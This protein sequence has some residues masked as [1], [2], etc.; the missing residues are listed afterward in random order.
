MATTEGDTYRWVAT[1]GSGND[2]EELGASALFG[3]IGRLSETPAIGPRHGIGA[4][5]QQQQS[6]PWRRDLQENSVR[7]ESPALSLFSGE[8]PP[9]SPQFEDV[10]AQDIFECRETMQRYWKTRPSNPRHTWAEKGRESPLPLLDDEMPPQSP[11]FADISPQDIIECRETMR[12]YWTPRQNF[13]KYTSEKNDTSNELLEDEMPP[14]SP[15]FSD[16]SAQDIANYRETIR[17]ARASFS[18]TTT[19]QRSTWCAPK[20]EPLF[21]TLRKPSTALPRP[22]LAG[23][24]GLQTQDSGAFDSPSKLSGPSASLVPD[25]DADSDDWILNQEPPQSPLF[26][27]YHKERAE[28]KRRAEAMAAELVQPGEIGDLEDDEPTVLFERDKVAERSSVVEHGDKRERWFQVDVHSLFASPFRTPAEPRVTVREMKAYD[29]TS[30]PLVAVDANDCDVLDALARYLALLALQARTVPS[31]NGDTHTAQRPTSLR[32]PSCSK[33]PP[34]LIDFHTPALSFVVRS[35]GRRDGKARNTFP[36]DKCV[37]AVDLEAMVEAYLPHVYAELDVDYATLEVPA[38]LA[39]SPSTSSAATLADPPVSNLRPRATVP[40]KKRP[41]SVGSADVVESKHCPPPSAIRRALSGSAAPGAETG[42][43]KVP[44]RIAR[45]QGLRA[46]VSVMNLRGPV[47]RSNS[48]SSS[49]T[50]GA[51]GKGPNGLSRGLSSGLRGS[52][53]QPRSPPMLSSLQ[54]RRL[55]EVIQPSTREPLQQKRPL[56]ASF[57]Y[58]SSASADARPRL[59]SPCSSSLST[60]SLR[61]SPVADGGSGAAHAMR[62]N[63]ASTAAMPRVAG[64]R[65]SASVPVGCGV[66]RA[67]DNLRNRK[68]LPPLMLATPARRRGLSG[69]GSALPNSAAAA[70]ALRTAGGSALLSSR[71]AIARVQPP[72]ASVSTSA[73]ALGRRRGASAGAQLAAPPPLSSQPLYAKQASAVATATPHSASAGRD[74]GSR[75][76]HSLSSVI[77]ERDPF[78]FGSRRAQT[79]T[80]RPLPAVVSRDGAVRRAD[81]RQV[82]FSRQNLPQTAYATPTAASRR[83]LAQPTLAQPQNIPPQRSAVRQRIGAKIMEFRSRI[84]SP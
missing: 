63:G 62:R 65:A 30:A 58:Q 71:T 2:S 31:E 1:A 36:A 17:Q 26:A 56:R 84:F 22:S 20:T 16:V 6:V 57:S 82:F 41:D 81:V 70:S 67:T 19:R 40:L 69:Q 46:S 77:V 33:L 8:M 61:P 54:P 24:L 76:R 3:P 32:V 52:R 27:D 79:S 39:R 34:D 10:S 50:N 72:P 5:Q 25:N 60:A 53:I 47:G 42:L 35:V 4:T 75:P 59:V 9:Q 55:S 23:M 44:G 14:H 73:L 7:A 18:C 12:R 13:S 78:D 11:F 64:V 15:F 37:R 28:L 43:P 29:R 38:A 83:I 66:P 68:D 51:A 49:S 45:P 74:A 80:P 48:C 21:P